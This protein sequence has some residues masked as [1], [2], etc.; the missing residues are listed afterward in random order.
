MRTET[1]ERP[2]EC[3]RAYVPG[4]KSAPKMQILPMT[5]RDIDAI[6]QL[7]KDAGFHVEAAKELARSFAHCWVARLDTNSAEPDAFLLAWQAA[8]ELDVI[9]IA[10]AVG[11]RRRG[12]ARALVEQLLR[13]AVDAQMRRVIL[14][15]R[16]SNVAAIELYRSF[17]FEEGRTRE[18]YY[19]EPTE[20]GIE[21]SLEINDTLGAPKDGKHRC[22]EA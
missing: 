14:E 4:V 22:L 6:D 11:S 5:A 13:Y 12:L 8:D 2:P 15:V 21:M 1:R 20:D 10:S 7:A 16:H 9:A 19:S 3:L 18:G 17:G